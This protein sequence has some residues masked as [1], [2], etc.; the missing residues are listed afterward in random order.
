MFKYMHYLCM[1]QLSIITAKLYLRGPHFEILLERV[2]VKHSE[3]FAVPER[4][5][6]TAV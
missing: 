6:N 4:L 1:F 5:E 2:S 3:G